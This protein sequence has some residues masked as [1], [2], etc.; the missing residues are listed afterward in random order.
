MNAPLSCRQIGTLVEREPASDPVSVRAMT[1]LAESGEI[2]RQ[3][4]IATR[5]RCPAATAA[6]LA[7]LAFPRFD[8]RRL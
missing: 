6:L 5:F 2:L 4:V 3:A 8:E 1:Q 7:E